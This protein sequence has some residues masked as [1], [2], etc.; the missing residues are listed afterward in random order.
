MCAGNGTWSPVLRLSVYFRRREQM[1]VCCAGVLRV[2]VLFVLALCVLFN[3]WHTVRLC[4]ISPDK[5]IDI[6]IDLYIYI[7]AFV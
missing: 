2:F 6:P 7:Y 5:Y 4:Y 1:L 3:C